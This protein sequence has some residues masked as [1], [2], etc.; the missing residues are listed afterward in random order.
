[1]PDD[2]QTPSDPPVRSTECSATAYERQYLGT[3]ESTAWQKPGAACY[4]THRSTKEQ[5]QARILEIEHEHGRGR[6]RCEIMDVT[7]RLRVRWMDTC[8]LHQSPN[9]KLSD[10][11]PRTPDSR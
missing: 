3:W 8:E 11:G 2:F 9:D 1:M 5:L 10:G 6:A 7:G 4:Y